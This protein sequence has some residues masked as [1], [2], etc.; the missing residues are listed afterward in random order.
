MKNIVKL[1]GIIAIVAVIGFSLAACSDGGDGGDIGLNGLWKANN[2]AQITISGNSGVT[3]SF[4]TN[5]PTLLKDA[6]NKG[7]FKIG[8]KEFRN[9]TSKGNL[10][11][12]G[13][14]LSV[15]ITPPNYTVATGVE[16][17]NSTFTLSANGQ[18][19]KA[20]YGANITQTWTKVR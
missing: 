9:L 10:T 3:T 15:T 19:L 13:Q 12:S 17:V 11:W 5:P 20:V 8:Q 18:T 16:W 14:V 6:I 1:I 4:P 2:G 7:Y